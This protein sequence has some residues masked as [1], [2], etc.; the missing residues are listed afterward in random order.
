MKEVYK[1]IIHYN[2]Q[3]K[4]FM[5]ANII[6]IILVPVITLTLPNLF[7]KL[8]DKNIKEEEI[9]STVFILIILQLLIQMGHIFDVY[10]Y[11]RIVNMIKKTAIEN[12]FERNKKSSTKE[13]LSKYLFEIHKLED[14][15]TDYFYQLK[16]NILAIP[17]FLI[18]SIIYLLQ[19]NKILGFGLLSLLICN[20]ILFRATKNS[21]KGIYNDRKDKSIKI[22]SNIEDILSNMLSI[23]ID[24]NQEHELNGLQENLN[25]LNAI[26]DKS[27]LCT[28]KFNIAGLIV[29]FIF[30][31]LITYISV[32]LSKKGKITSS[33]LL[34]VFF[35]VKQYI[36]YNKKMVKF[37]TMETRNSD[38][39]EEI[40]WMLN[41]SNKNFNIK[42]K[43][44]NISFEL[45]NVYFKYDGSNDYILKNINLK[46]P[47]KKVV[48]IKGK[49]GSGKSTLVKILMGVEKP[50]K[51]KFLI[52]NKEPTSKTIE[53]LYNQVGYM[54]QHPSLFNKSIIENVKYGNINAT[55]EQVI[56]LF[57]KFKIYKD[58]SN[59][60]DGL[61]TIVGSGG[62][63]LSGGQKQ[64]I[65]FMRLYLKDP[66]VIIMDEPTSALDSKTR[67]Q[68]LNIID[69][70]V[71]NKTVIIIS[72]DNVFDNMADIRVNM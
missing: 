65:L 4:G 69:E 35:I 7:S 29:F 39:M 18:I 45:K 49:I 1:F 32:K 3:N 10:Q 23:K 72:H 51:G 55:D 70:I 31:T 46:I 16:Q 9:L 54:S 53:I 25:D 13:E 21:C 44:K 56:N 34:T 71:L 36:E 27:I 42:T 37:V 26:S 41:T 58:F 64:I 19:V 5:I 52:N 59:L 68:L 61:N 60:K 22:V 57:K 67:E 30:L 2:K 28:S 14:I 6:F 38:V 17:V 8:L 12:I 33:V 24:N 66:E 63:N 62:S 40:D 15:T 50:T 20:L 11:T 43:F 47:S 48:L